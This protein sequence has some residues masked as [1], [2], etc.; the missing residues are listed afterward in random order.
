MTK[1]VIT[2]YVYDHIHTKENVSMNIY[3][4]RRTH[5]RKVPM[6]KEVLSAH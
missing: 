4:D 2:M 3:M 6:S 1:K 5:K